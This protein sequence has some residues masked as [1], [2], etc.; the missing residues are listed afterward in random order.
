MKR[1]LHENEAAR[2]K[3]QSQ[4]STTIKS[5]HEKVR[6]EGW[7]EAT[8]QEDSLQQYAEA[9]HALAS[10]M[11]VPGD[12]SSTHNDR[13]EWCLH[14]VEQYYRSEGGGARVKLLAKEVR[15]EAFAANGGVMPS[16]ETLKKLFVDKFGKI[17]IEEGRHLDVL[18]VG[19][20]YNPF[21]THPLRERL[22]LHVRAVD[23][24]PS[25]SSS[26]VERLDWLD[27]PTVTA[28]FSHT[29]DVVIMCL[30]LSYL[31]TPQARFVAI[32]SGLRALRLYGLLVLVHT[33]TQCPRKSNWIEVWESVL[34][35][36]GCVRVQREVRKH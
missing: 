13:L 20:C 15:K 2:K 36:L 9:M 26:G 7:E 25:P 4:L 19:S 27:T 24:Y 1:I 17:E 14:V 30:M 8:K 21:A 29:E 3:R 35:D 22:Q 12:T 32:C 6:Q 5:H 11:W 28:K 18:D 16:D 33:R 23:L 10:E 34:E 31:P